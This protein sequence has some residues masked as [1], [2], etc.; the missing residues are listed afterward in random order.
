MR[1]SLRTFLLAALILPAILGALWVMSETIYLSYRYDEEIW[2]E[3]TDDPL[4]RKKSG[5]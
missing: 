3:A 2:P 1:F 4:N 5:R